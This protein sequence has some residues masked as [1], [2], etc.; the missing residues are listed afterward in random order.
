MGKVDASEPKREK[1]TQ[2]HAAPVTDIDSSLSMHRSGGGLPLAAR[3]LAG[4]WHL[5][6]VRL[7][8]AQLHHRSG[9][10]QYVLGRRGDGERRRHVGVSAGPAGGGGDG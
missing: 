10:G 3:S 2:E 5:I 8:V 4:G 9:G 7:V 6:L 1:T